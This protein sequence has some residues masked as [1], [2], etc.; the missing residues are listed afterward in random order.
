MILLRDGYICL[1]PLCDKDYHKL[2]IHHINYDK[3]DCDLKNLITLCNKCNSRANSNRE[4][5]TEWYKRILN[6]RYYE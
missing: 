3:Q 4:W 6:R 2:N 1:N 5:H